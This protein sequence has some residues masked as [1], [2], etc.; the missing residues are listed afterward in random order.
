MVV[1]WGNDNVS[2]G[3]YKD[4]ML[5]NNERWFL[6]HHINTENLELCFCIQVV[7]KATTF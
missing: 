6:L 5:A 1:G 4:H 7:F 3:F 2:A